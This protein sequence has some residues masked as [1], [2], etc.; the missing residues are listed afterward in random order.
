MITLPVNGLLVPDLPQLLERRRLTE[1]LR[2]RDYKFMMF[3]APLGFGK[4]S[5]AREYAHWFSTRPI[6]P[7]AFVWLSLDLRHIKWDVRLFLQVLLRGLKNNQV[8]DQF[9]L[10]RLEQDLEDLKPDRELTP[11]ALSNL[12]Y[13]LS[14]A[15]AQYNRP[16]LLVLDD[17]HVVSEDRQIIE[18]VNNLLVS[19]PAN[20]RVLITSRLFPGLDVLKLTMDDQFLLVNKASL[21]FTYEEITGLLELR[22]KDPALARQIEKRS[23]GWAALVALSLRVL[24]NPLVEPEQALSSASGGPLNNL[25]STL[26]E[27]T[28]RNLASELQDFLEDVSVL[29]GGIDAGVAGYLLDQPNGERLAASYLSRLEKLG[30]AERHNLPAQ[31]GEINRPV[32]RL[33]SLLKEHLE[34]G[35]DNARAGLL[36]RQ[37]AGY[38]QGRGDWLLAFD[39]YL[40]ANDQM[41]AATLLE[42]VLGEQFKTNNVA[43]IASSIDRLDEN[44]IA[45]FPHL[46]L[47][48]GRSR[49]LAGKIEKA[50]SYYFASNRLWGHYPALDQLVSEEDDAFLAEEPEPALDLHVLVSK[51]ETISRIAHAW[52]NTGRLP[53]ALRALEGVVQFLSQLKGA[54]N[55]KHWTHV[56]ALSRR[57]LGGFYLNSGQLNECIE[58]SNKALSAFV[59]LGDEYNAAGARHN[60]GIA[61]RKLGNQAQAEREFRNALEYW[62]RI[63]G[64]QLPNTLNSLAVGLVN[65]GRYR[66][67]IKLFNEAQAKAKETGYEKLSHYL[68]AGMGDAYAGLR[69]WKRALPQYGQAG[70]EADKQNLPS[71][72]T[73]AQLGIARV[74]RRSGDNSQSWK[75]LLKALSYS[76]G[77]TDL[78]QAAVAVEMGAYQVITSRFEM[79]PHQLEGALALAHKTQDRRIEA[80]TYFWLS[81]LN[82]RQGR[83]RQAQELMRRA[84]GLSQELGYDAFLIEEV[85]ELPEFSAFFRGQS[86]EQLYTFFSRDSEEAPPPPLQLLA[87]GK[88]RVLLDGCEVKMSSKKAR[89]LIFYLLEE[90]SPVRGEKIVEML[91]PEGDLAG[92]GLGSGFYSTITHARRALGGPDTV[93]AADGY[94]SLNLRYRYDVEEFEE[95][96]ARAERQLDPLSRIELLKDALSL[97]TEDFLGGG[98]L[99]W[100]DIRREN[101]RQKWLHA[102]HLLAEANTEANRPQ[103][104]L[105]IWAKAMNAE[106][107]DEQPL[108]AYA[109]LLAQLKS[110]TVAVNFLRRKI[111]AMRADDFEPEEAT[112]A[113][114][115]DLDGSRTISKRR[116]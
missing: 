7:G 60:L 76:E 71:M 92:N 72:L 93:R 64:H 83:P 46:L 67:A 41:Q 38:Y 108:R 116:A 68:L 37:A 28:L 49:F 88:G 16:L 4:T 70:V 100:M 22:G 39:H 90:K 89:E 58:Q 50:I 101:L 21:R 98:D 40:K 29:E 14:G 11:D 97:Y 36:H 20:L 112:L 81:F 57:M 54:Q 102:L 9:D 18:V 80:T 66:E 62:Q 75:A 103:I 109:S 42:S 3:V 115:R 59:S 73:Y 17:F 32:F 43:E 35:L 82:F 79:A 10:T 44:I 34:A 69:E 19:S 114:L 30:L 52:M 65:E 85:N 55:D 24:D 25:F 6:E 104:A 96:L 31:S 91:W 110:K 45:N 105:E 12:M 15:L 107:I 51:A 33:H 78:D 74:Y 56:L 13:A 95:K 53:Q 47:V 1:P 84:I 113:L 94:Y 86:S 111:E 5:L 26:V 2:S 61:W 77:G 27:E 8:G 48:A 106:P 99:D 23:E 63:G 87:F